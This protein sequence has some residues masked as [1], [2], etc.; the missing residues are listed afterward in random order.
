MVQ[1]RVVGPLLRSRMMGT[2]A[3]G[4]RR[5]PLH[6]LHQ[7]NG[8]HLTEF[9]GWDMPLYYSH[10]IMSEHRHCRAHAGLFDVSHMVGVRI[11]GDDRV[12]F[13][14]RILPG[15]ADGI[16]KHPS[17]NFPSALFTALKLT[18]RSAAW[19]M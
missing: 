10:G 8:A 14:E 6:S 11:T 9:G 7:E 15:D 17:S 5:T 3:E 19:N 18:L 16:W 1:R 4:L 13:A 12:A 2:A